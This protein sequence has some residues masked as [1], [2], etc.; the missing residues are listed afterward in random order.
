MRAVCPASARTRLTRQRTQGLASEAQALTRARGGGFAGKYSLSL[1]ADVLRG[2]EGSFDIEVP[3]SEFRPMGK[4]L[5]DW[6]CCTE[7]KNDKLEITGV[8]L[9][10]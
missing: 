3:L 4:G 8:Q 10:R 6:S 2:D 1:A 9:L 7:N 5:A